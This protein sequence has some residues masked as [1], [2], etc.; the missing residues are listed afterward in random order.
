MRLAS[1]PVE[2]P[3]TIVCRQRASLGEN[4]FDYAYVKQG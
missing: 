1:E 2:Q 4:T 3:A